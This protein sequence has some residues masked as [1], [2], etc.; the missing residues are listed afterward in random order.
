MSVRVKVDVTAAVQGLHELEKQHI[1]FALAATLT[2]V[3]K[4]AQGEVQGQL[5]SRFTLRNDFTQ[6]GIRIKPAEKKSAVIEADVHTDTANRKTGAPDYLGKQEDGG[7]RVAFGGHSHIA[8][9]TKYLRQMIGESSPIPAE[10]R[11]KAL[12][13][14]V[15]GRYATRTRKGQMALRNQVTVRGMVFFVQQSRSGTP[16][17][18]GRYWTDHEAY[19]FYILAR[20]VRTKPR[21]A[22]DK[23]VETYVQQNFQ[24]AWDEQ[25][26]AMRAKGLRFR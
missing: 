21:L 2:K 13:T 3:V 4:G 7:E 25:W 24:K 14:A 22:M 9:P 15:N 20:S 8:I 18:M 5:P 16:M 12:L 11:P 17:I 10:L 19:P 1:P 26:S 6:K 23:T